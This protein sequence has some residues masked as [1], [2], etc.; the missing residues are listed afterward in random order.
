MALYVHYLYILGKIQKHEYPPKLTSQM[1]KAAM[2][3]EQ[4]KARFEFLRENN[5]ATS[6][7][8]AT[9]QN[10]TE[11][12]L[13]VL[14]KQR[15]ILNVRKKKRRKLYDA[16]ADVEALCSVKELHEKG[17]S[18]ME[19]GFSRYENSVKMLDN[20]GISIAQITAE[21]VEIYNQLAEINREI[22]QLRHKLELC[23]KIEIEA[24]Q[25]KSDIQKTENLEVS[26]DERR[27]RRSR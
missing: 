22:Q 27:R 5:I 21:K 16:L 12:A 19:D 18:G 24:P 1:R 2:D 15:T 8:I 3:F 20:C 23:K 7:D 11:K 14:I 10:S 9:F 17:L 13:N 6:E 4:Y 25:I 26:R